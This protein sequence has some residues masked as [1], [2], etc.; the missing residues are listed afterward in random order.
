M[1]CDIRVLTTAL[2]T[3]S[4]YRLSAHPVPLPQL[5]VHFNNNMMYEALVLLPLTL[6]NLA[7]E[8]H[9]T[10]HILFYRR[11]EAGALAHRYQHHPREIYVEEPGAHSAVLS[12]PRRGARLG[13]RKQSAFVPAQVANATPQQW[14]AP[15]KQRH[16][17]NPRNDGALIMRKSWFQT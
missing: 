1:L 6:L 5:A 14:R 7:F 12:A 13:R 8:P 15:R 10:K 3:S 9:I 2:L 4:S 16:D 17:H 11:G